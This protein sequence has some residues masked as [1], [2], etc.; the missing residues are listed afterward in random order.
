[1]LRYYQQ[2]TIDQLYSLLPCVGQSDKM[3]LLTQ[4]EAHEMCI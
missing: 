4:G 1:M 2:N 3:D